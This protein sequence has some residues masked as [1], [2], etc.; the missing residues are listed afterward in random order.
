[1]T[2]INGP[3]NCIRLEGKIN[4]IK[5]ILYLF[6]DIHMDIYE[7]TQCPTFDS[8]D[9]SNF[10]YKNIKSSTK[11]LDFFFEI[12][13]S[14]IKKNTHEDLIDRKKYIWEV[15]KLFNNEFNYDDKENKMKTAKSN[16]KVRLHY[17]DIREYIHDNISIFLDNLYDLYYS[18]KQKSRINK[19]ISQD[20]FNNLVNLN[21]ELNIWKLMLFAKKINRKKIDEKNKT[22]PMPRFIYKIYDG[23]HNQDIKNKLEDMFLNVKNYLDTAIDGITE[24]INLLKRNEEIINFS[25]NKLNAELVEKKLVLENEINY[26]VD[27][28]TFSKLI[29]DVFVLLDKINLSVMKT[30]LYLTDIYCLRRVL[31]KDYITNMIIYTGAYHTSN[32]IYNLVKFFD[33]KITHASYTKEA[34]LNKIN[35]NILN[36]KKNQF[37]YVQTMFYPATLIQCTDF[38]KLPKDFE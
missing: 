9:F 20:F 23:Y 30:F 32:Y 22:G 27:E 35:N 26:G 12:N 1:M 19:K 16:N 18:S 3:I 11:N 8:I 13:K 14:Y 25:S 5:K 34:N 36:S 2:F 24:L 38:S 33:F 10:L 29:Y 31:D 15:T 4:N 6:M 21:M 37:N 17:M 7:Q 28:V